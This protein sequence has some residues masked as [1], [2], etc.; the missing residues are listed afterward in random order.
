MSEPHDPSVVVTGRG[1]SENVENGTAYDLA[2]VDLGNAKNVVL[3]DTAIVRR[4]GEPGKVQ[5]FMAKILAFAGHPPEPMNIGTTRKNMGC[6]VRIEKD[7][8]MFA[9]QKM[10]RAKYFN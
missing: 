10:T 4:C 8:L 9:Y 3:P 2:V 7:A 6:A 1:V 5:L